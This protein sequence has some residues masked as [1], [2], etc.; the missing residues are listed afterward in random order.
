M[1]PSSHRPLPD[2]LEH[3]LDRYA[4][5]QK[6]HLEEM[7]QTT[8][9]DFD[10]LFFHRKQAFESLKNRLQEWHRRT[11]HR[12]DR[13]VCDIRA[14]CRARLTEIVKTDRALIQMME[15]LR[16]QLGQRLTRMRHGK[17][18]LNG[19]AQKSTGTPPK[20]VYRRG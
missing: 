2:E 7:Q 4:S 3:S 6:N 14:V 18:A 1:I 5:L 20:F 19:Y 15:T 8:E 9:P 11:S 17:K 16:N 12:N 10:T 13:K